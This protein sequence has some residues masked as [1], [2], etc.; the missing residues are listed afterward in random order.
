MDGGQNTAAIDTLICGMVTDGT[1]GL[2]DGLYVFVTNSATNFTLNW[3]QNAYNLTWTSLGT[4]TFAANS[5]LTGDA[6]S[7]YANTGFNPSSA[8]GHWALSSVTM[9]SCDVNSRTTSQSWVNLGA[10]SAGSLYTYH[11]PLDAGAFYYDI[12][13]AFFP[14]YGAAGNVQGSWITTRNSSGTTALYLNGTSV[15]TPSDAEAG[16]T[17][18]PIF[19]MG[20]N[21]NGSFGSITG[22]KLA[23]AFFGSGMS[24]V[25]VGNMRTRLQTYIAAVGGSGC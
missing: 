24:A 7:C 6:A 3:A 19:I 1:Y 5:G 16:L 22:D 23:Y 8:G 9:G 21:S 14:N 20:V 25:Q 10:N 13:S 4:C 17:V 11:D 15:L 2:L 18:F 12:G